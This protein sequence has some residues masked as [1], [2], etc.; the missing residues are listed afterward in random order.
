MSAR[1]AL[2]GAIGRCRLCGAPRCRDGG[3]E[4]RDVRRRG[5]CEGMC[6][7]AAGSPVI[8]AFRPA[9]CR[10][11]SAWGCV[12]QKQCC[13]THCVV[14]LTALEAARRHW[15]RERDRAALGDALLRFASAFFVVC[16]LQAASDVYAPVSG[17]VKESN[18]AL[19]ETPA[20][21]S[22]PAFA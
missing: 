13:Q 4:G 21:V 10:A 14:G 20:M 16:I 6:A 15:P 7:T 8:P 2:A 12:A 11:A 1:M 17:T 22:V 19:V 5:V 3:D 9:R 18:S